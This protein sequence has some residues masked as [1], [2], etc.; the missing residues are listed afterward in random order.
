[1]TGLEERFRAGKAWRRRYDDALA[2]GASMSGAIHMANS[3]YLC[4]EHGGPADECEQCRDERETADAQ[5]ECPE[6]GSTP[7]L[8]FCD[9]GECAR[10]LDDHPRDDDDRLN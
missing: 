8:E 5:T 6:C 3:P 2:H 7:C 9:C 4:P 1:M 10:M